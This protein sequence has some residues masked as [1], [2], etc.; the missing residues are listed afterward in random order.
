M[1]PDKVYLVPATEDGW[2]EVQGPAGFDTLY[3]P[4]E[5]DGAGRPRVFRVSWLRGL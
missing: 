4:V 1:T 3:F 2:F 5:S